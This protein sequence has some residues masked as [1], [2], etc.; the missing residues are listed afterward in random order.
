M[1]R[2]DPHRSIRSSKGFTL[3][4]LL[5]VIA[6]IAILASMLLPALANAKEKAK[7]VKCFS[8]QKQIGYAYSMYAGDN[9]DYYP[10]A[11][12]IASVGGND[13][14]LWSN[15]PTNGS[16]DK[17]DRPLNPYVGAVETFRCPSDRGDFLKGIDNC[18]DQMGN[19]YRVAWW[20]AFRVAQ[21]IGIRS[22]PAGSPRATP[23]KESAVA[24][25]AATK[26]IQ[27]DW[28]WHGNRGLEDKRSIW[29]NFKGQARYAV[30]FGD[31]HVEFVDWPEEFQSWVNVPP[32]PSFLWW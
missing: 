3:I 30:L 23:I 32:D 10:L 26:V 24:L 22:Y 13:G 20:N 16:V 6:I 7:R 14:T 31:H 25:K 29:H 21:V 17:E 28:I 15:Q 12:G 27:G 18:Y 5:V 19:S 8:N 1:I 2:I 4:E 11:P 9:E